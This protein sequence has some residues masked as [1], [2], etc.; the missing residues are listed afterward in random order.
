[1]KKPRKT[2]NAIT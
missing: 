2:W 1:M